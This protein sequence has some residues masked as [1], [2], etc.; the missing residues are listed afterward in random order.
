[1]KTSAPLVSPLF[2]TDTQGQL[3]A[4]LLLHPE[5]E[6]SLSDLARLADTSI[7]TVHR[8]IGRLVESGLFTERR[9]GRN[10]Y[11]R[12]NTSHALYRPVREIVEY[13]YG[14][15]AV[16]PTLLKKVSGIEEAFVFGSW[17]ARFTGAPGPDPEDIDVLIIGTP[18][19]VEL[20]DAVEQAQQ[21]LGREVNVQ[22]LSSVRWN[23]STPEPFVETVRSRPLVRLNLGGVQ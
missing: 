4:W 18:D 8:E 3:L 13:C 23:A 1:M 12:P 19:R 5:T 16:L 20:E 14:P 7:P 22:T 11:V 21:R 15:I 2:R 6:R 10:R 9:S 17:A